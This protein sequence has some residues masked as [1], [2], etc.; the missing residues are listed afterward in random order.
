MNKYLFFALLFILSSCGS[1]N[2]KIAK[3]KDKDILVSLDKGPCA[4]RCSE[5]NIKVYKNGY[6]V[7]E[8]KANVEKYGL[9]AKKIS[10]TDLTAISKAFDDNEF[11]S[12]DNQYPNP[13]P[14]MPVITMVYN[15]DTKSKT[16]IGGLDRPKKIL[17]LQRMLE[18]LTRADG[19]K[20]LKAYEPKITKILSN[21]TDEVK[22]KPKS[23][24]IESE[25]V[26]EI[27]P[28]AFMS[29]W[30]QKYKDQQIQIVNK[31]SETSSIWLIT[32][33]RNIIQSQAM[34]DKL[35]Q[36]PQVKSAEFNKST[37]PR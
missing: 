23:Y 7:Y 8:G 29:Q 28:S 19:F 12:F 35:K 9:Y 30:I 4:T 16:I 5:Y 34:L 2:N 13:D 18:T 20:L 17:D 37:T 27:L 32:Y 10:S 6:V 22:E 24:I 26:V 31:L 11:F 14:D 21:E 33:N 1:L 15:K 36:D 25:I 3:L